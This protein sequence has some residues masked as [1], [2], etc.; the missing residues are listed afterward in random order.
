MF[1]LISF[2]VLIYG[3]LECKLIKILVITPIPTT[4]FSLIIG[5]TLWYIYEVNCATIYFSRPDRFK[6]LPEKYNT[7]TTDI[8][9][10]LSAN[11][12][13]LQQCTSL[14]FNIVSK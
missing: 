4:Q 3:V 11:F 14:F 1:G 2:C 5:C 10:C 6:I 7:Y 9:I 12:H 8:T 13:D